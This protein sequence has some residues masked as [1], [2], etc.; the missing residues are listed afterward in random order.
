MPSG[1][2]RPQGFDVMQKE[3]EDLVAS[4][5]NKIDEQRSE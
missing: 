1:D 3:D 2:E 4:N 5:V